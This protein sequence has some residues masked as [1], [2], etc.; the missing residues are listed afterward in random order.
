[1]T[2]T[3]LALVVL[4][5][6]IHATW[7]LLSKR[8]ASAGVRFIAAYTAIACVSYFP[9][10]A[11]LLAQGG[12]EWTWSVAAC[13]IVSG[14]LHLGYSLCLQRGYQVAELS[15]V[16]PVARGS[17]P[18]L[19]SIAAFT[20]FDEHPSVPG[21]VGLTA[22]VFGIVLISTRGD[23]SGFRSPQ[24]FAGLSWGMATGGLIAAY[25]VVDTFGVKS[26]SI[27]PVLLDWFASTVRFALLAPV[28]FRNLA[29]ARER[30]TGRWWTAFAVGVL[31]PLSYILVLIAIDLGARL[32]L[33]APAREMA[34][35]V[36]ALLGMVIL[37]EALGV[38]RL[39]GCAILIVGVLC[40]GH[41]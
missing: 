22:V 23:L 31:S 19:S 27:H 37:R 18:M 2:L 6:F 14:V 30:L 10:V 41:G 36:G 20:L 38:W 25:T 24:G 32:S 28:L 26:L 15:V 35:M 11:W 5:A 12:I 21:V 17:A 13:L 1:V 34:M 40:L 9:W 4:A 3:S 29:T 8:A 39:V 33:V 16:Y 7:N